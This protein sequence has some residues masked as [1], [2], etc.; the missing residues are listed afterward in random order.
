MTGRAS[1]GRAHRSQRAPPGSQRG[2]Q[3]LWRK[4]MRNLREID[5]DQRPAV[6]GPT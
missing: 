4:A 5:V 2:L 1:A 6:P 3:E